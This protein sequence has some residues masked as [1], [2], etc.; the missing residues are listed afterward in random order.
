MPKNSKPAEVPAAKAVGPVKLVKQKEQAK[1][2]AKAKDKPNIT[3]G[4]LTEKISNSVKI[5]SRDAAKAVDSILDTIQETLANGDEVLISGF[6]KF[7]VLSKKERVGRNP[8]TGAP[9]TITPRKIL[10][11][12]A[13]DKLKEYLNGKIE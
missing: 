7:E 4:T 2:V 10:K 13:S 5:S 3:R 6:G 1:P 9:V 12:R 11:F 8:Q